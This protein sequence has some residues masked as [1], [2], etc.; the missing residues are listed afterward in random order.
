MHR[1]TCSRSIASIVVPFLL[2]PLATTT[3]VAGESF[4]G[5]GDATSMD[6]IIVPEEASDQ[7]VPDQGLP[8]DAFGYLGGLF[9]A[10][11]YQP[12]STTDDARDEIREAASLYGLDLAMMMSIAKV[13]SDFNPRVRTGSYKTSEAAQ[14]AGREI[15]AAYPIVQVSIYD[16]IDNSHTLVAVTPAS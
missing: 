11:F 15:K 16:S 3:V 13:E 9:E 7:I 14:A 2:V 1:S 5:L 8:V 4:G 6:R 12:H 10:R